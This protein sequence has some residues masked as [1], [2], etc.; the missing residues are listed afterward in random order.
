MKFPQILVL[1]INFYYNF[2][3]E[4]CFCCVMKQYTETLHKVEGETIYNPNL[5]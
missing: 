4:S 2:A 3:K 1:I 5:R